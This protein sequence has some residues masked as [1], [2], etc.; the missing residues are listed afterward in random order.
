[1]VG[2]A[3][4]LELL[5][6]ARRLGTE[7]AALLREATGHTYA[8]DT[9]ST[10]TDMVTAADRA[11]ERLIVEGLRAARP[12]DAILGEEGTADAGTTGVRWIIDPLDGTTNFL[13]GI[14]AFAVSIAAEVDGRVAAGVVV[15]VERNECFTAALGHGA[16]LDGVPL[17]RRDATVLATALVA[18]GFGYDPLRRAE[19]GAVVAALLPLVRD[20][21]RVGAA[22][23]DLCWVAAGRVDAYYERGIQPWDRAAGAL[24][25]AEAGARVLVTERGLTIAAAPGLFDAL[26]SLVDAPGH[27]TA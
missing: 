4:P 10:E 21:R 14:P 3:D 9:K 20:I 18:T 1:L 6:L 26:R 27:E 12:D 15:D 5:D 25:A 8:V 2:V 13:Y 24:I 16:W 19:Q 22:A 7:A 17:R 23:I 11:S